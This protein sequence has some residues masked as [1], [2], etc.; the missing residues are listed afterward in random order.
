MKKSVVS[1]WVAGMVALLVGLVEEVSA[2]TVKIVE[3][4]EKKQLDVYVDQQLFTS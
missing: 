3:Q 4:K 1:V 2:Q